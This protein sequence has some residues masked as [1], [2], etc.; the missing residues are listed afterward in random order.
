MIKK[1]FTQKIKEAN[2]KK[3]DIQKK[4]E[5]TEANLNKKKNNLSTDASSLKSLI[6]KSGS[7]E[8][9]LEIQTKEKGCELLYTRLGETK[10]IATQIVG[11]EKC[12]QV[13]AGIQEKLVASAFKCE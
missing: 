2:D 13:L 9:K 10:T 1:I 8:R 11:H 4:A 5:A 3:E 12:E 6:C 7:E